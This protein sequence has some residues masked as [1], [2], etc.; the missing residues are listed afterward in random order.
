MRRINNDHTKPARLHYSVGIPI[1]LDQ[2]PNIYRGRYLSTYIP[3]YPLVA[4]RGRG[5]RRLRNVKND[6]SR[7][8]GISFFIIIK[9]TKTKKND[10][11]VVYIRCAHS[12]F[13]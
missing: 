10:A 2:L 9:K 4:R 1:N 5:I 6:P 12:V 3:A 8:G 7:G 13:I 11:L